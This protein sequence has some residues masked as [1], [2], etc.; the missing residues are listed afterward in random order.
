MWVTEEWVTAENRRKQLG[1]FNSLRPPASELPP[2]FEE[3]AATRGRV[4]PESEVGNAFFFFLP[5][6]FFSH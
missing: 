3:C 2:I 1:V 5:C 6:S 4:G